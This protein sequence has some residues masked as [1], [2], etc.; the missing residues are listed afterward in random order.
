MMNTPCYRTIGIVVSTRTCRA[1]PKDIS[2]NG[3]S[4]RFN[5]CRWRPSWSCLRH[6]LLSALPI[7][8]VAAWFLQLRRSDWKNFS[9]FSPCEAYFVASQLPGELATGFFIDLGILHDF[10][11]PCSELGAPE[12]PCW[13]I[14]NA[15]TDAAHHQRSQV[16]AWPQKLAMDPGA[17]PQLT[18]SGWISIFEPGKMS[19]YVDVLYL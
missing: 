7:S 12:A 3:T 8:F 15:C 14:S 13:N 9:I 19:I 11:W 16:A 17:R 5:V 10:G 1:H 18:E 4:N 6:G 2:N